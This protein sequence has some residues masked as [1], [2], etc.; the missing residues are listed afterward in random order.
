M[1]DY[2]DVIATLE[3]KSTRLKKQYDAVQKALV[4]LRGADETPAP[5]PAKAPRRRTPSH[6]RSKKG[7]RGNH[8]ANKDFDWVKGRK[9]WDEGRPVLEIA[10]AV[11]CSDAGV[12]YHAK[13]SKWPKRNGNAKMK[14]ADQ[15]KVP[16]AR[17][18]KPADRPKI[19]VQ[20]CPTCGKMTNVDPCEMCH[21]AMPLAAKSKR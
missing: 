15:P 9:M 18:V 4:S 17:K 20:K 10:A 12:Y 1:S 3:E 5:A 16:V 14:P 7:K 13:H 19:P 2:D 6:K 21:T 11:G 8:P